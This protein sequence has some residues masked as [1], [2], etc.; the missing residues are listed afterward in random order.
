MT[1]DATPK[2]YAAAN[3]FSVI[4]LEVVSRFSRTVKTEIL[5]LPLMLIVQKHFFDR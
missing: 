2:P 3:G 4:E 1:T 5:H